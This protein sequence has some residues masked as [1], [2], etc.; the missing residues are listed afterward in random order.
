MAKLSI[1]MPVFNNWSFTRNCISYFNK[2]ANSEID[3][4]IVDNGSTDETKTDISKA[5]AI[6]RYI[7]NANN[8]GFGHACN[9]GYKATNSDYV[10]FLNNDIMFKTSSY[11]WI[12]KFIEQVEDNCLV[13]P[14]G[15]YIDRDFN[16]KY[17]TNDVSK[18]INYISGWCLL[19][20]RKT[21]D[22]LIVSGNEGPFD[23]KTF[24]CY[25]EDTDLGFRA[26]NKKMKFKLY[27]VPII[28]IGKQ[29]SKKI[30]T[31]TLYTESKQKFIK[32]WEK[33]F[34]QFF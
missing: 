10:L 31:S 32:K 22:K 24:F 12:D 21:F 23:A 20:S 14:T 17:E 26:L 33:S 6:T 15:G 30:N 9:Q 8:C 16:F 28:H 19:G 27:D 1:V 34:A 11:E 2:T 3:L 4:I 25:F 18:P 29:T 7:R 5:A 13:G